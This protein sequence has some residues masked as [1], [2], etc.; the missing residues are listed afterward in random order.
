MPSPFAGMDPF[1]EAFWLDVHHRLVTYASDWLNEHLPGDLI[2]STEE[3]VAIDSEGEALHRIGPDVRVFSPS[4]ADPSEGVRSAGGAAIEAPYKLVVD[5]DPV[6]EAFVRVI[7]GG[8][9]LITVIEFLSPSNKRGEGMTVYRVKR[10]ELL[11]AGVNV[12]EIDLV[13][14]GNWRA[15]LE[16]ARV[17]REAAS[18]YRA[19]VREG[20]R[21]FGG[22]LFPIY[23]DR[24]AAEVPV[25]LRPTDARPMLPVQ[26]LIGWV[27]ER[28]RYGARVHYEQ[29]LQ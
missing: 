28:G 11:T 1:L 12:V 17:P 29:D 25:P 19:V 3:R 14:G 2:A 7:D 8:G 26:Q 20:G 23:F 21:R 22:Y 4:T 27:Y 9:T 18:P 5:L 6:T 16:P 13:R 15:L 24:P 10:D